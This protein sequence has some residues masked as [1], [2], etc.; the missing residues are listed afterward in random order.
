M[1]PK[2]IVID[3]SSIEN[4]SKYGFNIVKNR[5]KAQTAGKITKNIDKFNATLTMEKDK[6]FSFFDNFKAIPSAEEQTEEEIIKDYQDE[7]IDKE[8]FIEKIQKAKSKK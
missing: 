1:F 3:S 4:F 6:N 5:I 8:Q 2:Q 7:L